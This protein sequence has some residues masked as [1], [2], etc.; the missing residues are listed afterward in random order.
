MAGGVQKGDGQLRGLEDSLLGED[1]DAPGP[2]QVVGV[3]EG[4]PVVHPAQLLYGSGSVEQ[5]LREGGLAGIHVGQDS[6]DK[7]FHVWLPQF[8]VWC[9]RISE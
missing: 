3:Q 1:G 7:S 5:G 4:I 6:D 2:F 9:R 8:G